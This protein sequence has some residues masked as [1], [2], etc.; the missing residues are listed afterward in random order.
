M[1]NVKS[2]YLR[3][4][5]EDF[6]KRWKLIG[7]LVALCAVLFGVLGYRQ[8]Q[9]KREL[10]AEQ[11]EETEAYNE[12]ISE[13]DAAI[14][15]IETSLELVTQ[16]VA[17]VQQYIDESI[18]MKLDSQNI[19]MASVQY[20]VVDTG[21]TGNILNA[22]VQYVNDGGLKEA[23]A[24][25]YAD[26]DVK[27]W[28]EIITCSTAS[29]SL[30]ITVMHYDAEQ[31][32]KIMDIVKQ[33]VEEQAKAITS[34]HGQFTLKQ[35][36]ASNY[37]KADVNILNTQ[38]NNTNNLKNFSSN[39]ADFENKLASQKNSK[40]NYI[41]GN[42]PEVLE[43]SQPNAVVLTVCYVFAGIL[44]GVAVPLVIFVLQYIFS[45]R[46]RSKD[47]LVGMGIPVIGSC[48]SK[49]G[50]QPQLERNVMDLELLMKQQDLSAVYLNF[51][52][53]DDAMKTA[54][55][56][57]EKQ[58]KA[59][60][61]RTASGCQADTKAESL[62]EMI[63]CGS[64]LI[65]VQAGKTTFQQIEEQIRLCDRFQIKMLGCVVVE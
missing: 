13:Y 54:V 18:Y 63:T 53:E 1:N 5:I 41:E 45:N 47:N 8:A 30:T 48:S 35:T 49:K 51:L 21:N 29:N 34:V 6:C 26:L 17:E 61:L 10:S 43:V 7:C 9:V 20:A 44:F 24:E 19:Q 2:I 23:L 14:A 33:R 25:E 32:Q 22:L 31:A 60:G 56:D 55:A 59:S 28:R 50:H 27:Y 3:N 57:Y 62:K 37:V 39:K 58:I 65:F 64:C 46:I 4:L 38:N 36:D 15:D 40:N 42:E 16:Q 52:H 11:Q 12:R